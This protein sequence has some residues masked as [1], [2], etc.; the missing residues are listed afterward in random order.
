MLLQ[1]LP[2]ALTILRIFCAFLLV[3]IACIDGNLPFSHKTQLAA[4]FI[5]ILAAITDFLDGYLARKFNQVTRLGSILDPLADK[6]FTITVFYC[7]YSKQ[8]ISKNIILL[9]LLKDLLLIIGFIINRHNIKHI[10]PI[11][12]SKIST[13][14]Q[15]IG[16]L[17]AINN[18]KYGTNILQIGLLLSYLSLLHY[19][20]LNLRKL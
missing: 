20:K 13:A 1:A 11:Y 9:F 14:L 5:I 6:I 16:G 10:Q 19:A 18:A 7:L 12:L 17:M 15:F 4:S 3:P 2:L 8:L